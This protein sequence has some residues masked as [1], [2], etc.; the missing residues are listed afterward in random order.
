MATKQLTGYEINI[1]G[2]LK[3]FQ[4]HIE[5]HYPIPIYLRLSTIDH[6]MTD[7]KKPLISM[8]ACLMRTKASMPHYLIQARM[9]EQPQ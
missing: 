9:G 2:M 3:W 7:L 5:T 1:F 4:L 8:N 6:N